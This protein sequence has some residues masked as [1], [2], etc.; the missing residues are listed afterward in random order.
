MKIYNMPSDVNE[1]EKIIGGLFTWRQFLWIL[2]GTVIGLGVFAIFGQIIGA[3]PAL[4]LGLA[5]I[6]ASLPFVFYKKHE[7]YLFEYLKRKHLFKKSIKYL[8]FKV[9][10]SCLLYTSDAAD[11]S[12]PV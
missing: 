2:A 6:G 9:L 1:K 10:V 12:P 3:V 5:C 8:P 7:I 11:D 4:I